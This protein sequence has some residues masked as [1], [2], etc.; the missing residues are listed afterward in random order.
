MHY[1][2]TWRTG[3]SEL[4]TH[5]PT[6]K[7]RQVNI[8]GRVVT[9]HIL[10]AEKAIGKPLPPG[11]EVHHVDC[12]GWNNSPGNLVICPDHSYHALL[13]R[14]QRALDACGD[15]NF[16]KCHLCKQYGPA[17]E[18]YIRKDGKGQWHRTC[19]NTSRT[20]RKRRNK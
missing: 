3:N 19:G 7:Y 11:A 8:A 10:L 14:R 1:Q 9:E 2:R 20:D 4:Q 16:L 17:E 18:M 5:E 12:N 6:S 13:H 15:A